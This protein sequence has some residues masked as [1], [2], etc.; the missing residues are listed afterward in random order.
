[1]WLIVHR[2]G[3][4]KQ[5]LLLHMFEFIDLQLIVETHRSASTQS[6]STF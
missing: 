6:K 1:M 2:F 4:F 5:I 3:R